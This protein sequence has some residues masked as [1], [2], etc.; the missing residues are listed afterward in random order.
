MPY[1]ISTATIDELEIVAQLMSDYVR[2]NLNMA[3]WPCSVEIFKRDYSSGC[4]RMTVIYSVDRNCDRL[5]GFAAW[6]PSY[7]LHHCVHGASFIDFYVAPAY[8]GRGLAAALLCEI[9]AEITR[10]GWDFMRGSAMTGRASRLYARV[11]VCFGSNEYNVSGK[12][13][14]Q[15]ASLAGL[16]AREI[17]R[18]L[19]TKEMNYEP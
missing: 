7:D 8:R 18:G 17:V 14:R 3:A 13:L 9:A 11:G 1:K 16:P 10:L 12:A 19:P 2:Q 4:F 5:V 15:L 6:M